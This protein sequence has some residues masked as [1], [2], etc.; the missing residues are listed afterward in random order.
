MADIKL[1]YVNSYRLTFLLTEYGRPFASHNVA[2]SA[3][4]VG[5][6]YWLM[7]RPPQT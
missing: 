2:S 1:D 3:G 5:A 4:A 7:P 6:V